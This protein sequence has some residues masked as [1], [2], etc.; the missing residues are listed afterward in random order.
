MMR[1]EEFSITE[2]PEVTAAFTA[3]IIEKLFKKLLGN[4]MEL[5]P[6]K[7]RRYRIQERGWEEI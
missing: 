2:D 5:P 1:T 7:A 3:K 4:Y 6:P